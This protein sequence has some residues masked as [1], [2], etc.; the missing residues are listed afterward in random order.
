MTDLFLA[1]VG[2]INREILLNIVDDTDLINICKTSKHAAEIYKEDEFWNQRLQRIYG[3]DF[4][5]YLSNIDSITYKEIYDKISER[6]GD[7]ESV[8]YDC[9]D[10]KYLPLLKFIIEN[11]VDV[12]IDE[13]VESESVSELGQIDIL[14]YLLVDAENNHTIDKESVGERGLIPAVRSGQTK[15]IKYLVEEL[16][17]STSGQELYEAITEGH[18]DTTK[19]LLEKGSHPQIDTDGSLRMAIE[20]GST[21]IVKYLIEEMGFSPHE[22]GGYAIML[23]VQNNC[24]TTV[25]YLINV[26][27]VTNIEHDILTSARNLGYVEMTAYLETVRHLKNK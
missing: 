6:K 11:N 27:G 3:H 13:L 10:D 14:K 16:G 5:K 22:D 2:D 15:I 25:Q 23:A 4:S 8:C 21:E 26:A 19:Y 1:G 12:D 9:D 24:L 20:S 7:L 17:F 18:L